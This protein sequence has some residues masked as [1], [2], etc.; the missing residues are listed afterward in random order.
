MMMKAKTFDAVEMKQEIQE[1]IARE[2]EG[3][4]REEYWRYIRRG[5][6]EFRRSQRPRSGGLKALFDRADNR[7]AE[8]P[9]S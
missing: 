9:G 6:E 5:A 1:R 8:A 7:D 4:T 3:M 2:T